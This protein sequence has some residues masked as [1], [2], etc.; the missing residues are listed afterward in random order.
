MEYLYCTFDNEFSELQG[1]GVYTGTKLFLFKSTDFPE[2][3]NIQVSGLAGTKSNVMNMLTIDGR[4]SNK[5]Y[6]ID[7]NRLN[8]AELIIGNTD[9]VSRK[10]SM[11][12]FDL[13]LRSILS[14][15]KQENKQKIESEIKKNVSKLPL[16]IDINGID[17][18]GFMSNRDD[19]TKKLI[20]HIRA[21]TNLHLDTAVMVTFGV[22]SNTVSYVKK[23]TQEELD[24]V[25]TNIG[26][27]STNVILNL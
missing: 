6:Y 21:T 7:S 4:L 13:A 15:V 11:A 17:T 20:G 5:G 2:A 26:K 3:A 12:G 27:E 9:L 18:S 10:A 14:F 8:H 24:Q 19:V 25:V 1:G 23:F 22:I 16:S